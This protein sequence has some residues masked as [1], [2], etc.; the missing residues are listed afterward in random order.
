MICRRIS[1]CESFNLRGKR[2]GGE[3]GRRREIGRRVR[4]RPRCRRSPPLDAL[5]RN[6]QGGR[7]QSIK[8]SLRAV[9][10]VVFPVSP[11][12]RRALSGGESGRM[13]VAQRRGSVL[14]SLTEETKMVWSDG[15]QEAVTRPKRREMQSKNNSARAKD[16]RACQRLAHLPNRAPLACATPQHAKSQP[17]VHPVSPPFLDKLDNVQGSLGTATRDSETNVLCM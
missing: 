2:L 13:L 7:G 6:R 16:T 12:D 15:V 3:G 4:K 8:Y 17:L 1:R 11:T 10:T 9:A 5:C 14:W